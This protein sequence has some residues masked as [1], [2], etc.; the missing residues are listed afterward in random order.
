MRKRNLF[1]RGKARQETP[2][3]ETAPAAQPEMTYANRF[4]KRRELKKR[5]C[6]YIGCDTHAVISRLVRSLVSAGNDMTVGSYIDTVLAEHLSRYKAEINELYRQ[7][8][9]DLL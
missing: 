8:E 3:V 1:S 4:L 2:A 6:V 7:Q 9:G 5:Q